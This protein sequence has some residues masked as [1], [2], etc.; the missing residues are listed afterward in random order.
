VGVAGAALCSAFIVSTLVWDAWTQP[1][2]VD[3][4]YA[5]RS[6]HATQLSAAIPFAWSAAEAGAAWLRT[7]RRLRIGLADPRLA[8]R[9]LLWCWITSCLVLICLLAIAS[10][11]AA[12]AG[13]HR[14][15]DLAQGLRGGLYLVITA[16]V[17][18]ARFAAAP[19]PAPARGAEA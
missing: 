15:E 4:D 7:R 17:W 12:H 9:F 6:S 16:L 8:E 3:Y 1:S 2:L 5:R 11:V 19:R 14:I 13:A 10:G 18:R